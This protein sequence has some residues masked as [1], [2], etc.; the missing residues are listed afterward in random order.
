MQSQLNGLLSKTIH[1]QTIIFS[2]FLALF[3][4]CSQ[5]NSQTIVQKHGRLKVSGNKIVDKNNKPISLA[6]NSLFW[7]NAGDTSDF[8]NSQTVTHLSND[9]NSSI[10]R[11]A[12]GVKEV[13][14]GGN[15]YIDNPD[16]QKNKIQKVIDA[17]IANGIYVIIDW[18]T[19]EAEKYTQQAADF[20][21]EMAK[22]YGNNPN[23]IYEVYN[24]PIGQSW[25]TIKQYAE[26]VIA[27]IRSE[28]PDNLIIVG[29]ST[30][31]QDVDIASN[32][33]INDANTAYTLH[34][35]A[36]THSEGLRNKARTALSNGVA[37]FVTEW[38]AVNADGDGAADKAE[39]QR[40]LDFM[41]SEGISHVN[42][43]VSDKDE[44]ASI[45]APNTGISGLTS[46]SLT[47]TGN[48]VRGI[49]KNWNGTSTG[50]GDS[51]PPTDNDCNFG[52]PTASAL[53][54]ISNSSY[55][56]I[57]VI[58]NNGP[59]LSN[60]TNFTINWSLQNN[61]L[62]Q[63][64][65]NTNN[66][67]PNWWIDLN[68]KASQ[69][70]NSSQPGVTLSGTGFNNLDGDYWAAKDGDNFVLVSKDKGFS[71]YFSNSNTPPNC[72]SKTRNIA[73]ESSVKI[74]FYPNPASNTLSI[75]GI[76]E[77]VDIIISDIKGNLIINTS[78]NLGTNDIDISNLNK[79]S[80]FVEIKGAKTN[81]VSQFIKSK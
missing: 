51:N 44:G 32:N 79:G 67:S 56:N 47:E 23:V 10:I 26:T 64:S 78:G 4:F 59:N 28:D 43:S 15:G 14:D 29:S 2:L 42:W 36:G 63:F 3:I 48:F 12:M 62:W 19:H 38:G 74:K 5:A 54:S 18:H 17:A 81:K 8:Y 31:S 41:K 73:Q 55:S 13:W 22:L 76:D 39:T 34:F 68:S 7:S 11:V 57:H 71:I 30:W 20:F 75:S 24:E 46:N 25:P 37:V 52:A 53:P 69:N 27:A 35:Y 16:F 80:Y 61:G 21:K 65:M 58:G 70:F 1:N 6:G 77:K 49:I 40:W 66:G 9:W 45:V 72:S 50:G 33:P 60:V